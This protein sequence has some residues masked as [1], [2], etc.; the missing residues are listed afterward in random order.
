[1]DIP[2][3]S[4]GLTSVSDFIQDRIVFRGLV[5]VDP[6]LPPLAEY[7]KQAGQ[8]VQP[9]PRKHEPAYAG[10]V[11]WLLQHARRQAA[12]RSLIRRVL[13]IGDTRLSDGTAFDHI[14]QAGG[15][16][17]LIFIGAD[18]D[19]PAAISMEPTPGGQEL[20][21]AN[22]WTA[23][24][25]FEAY[26]AYKNFPIDEA[27][28]LLVD[29]DKT[30]IGARGR[31]DQVIDRARVQAVQDTVQGL[32]GEGF[33]KPVFLEAYQRLDR[34][35]YHPF[36][37]DNQ[38]YLAYI[39]LVL[40]SGYTSLGELLAEI[41][42]RERYTFSDFIG[43][44]EDRKAQLPLALRPIHT[45]IFD[46]VQSGDP[47]PFKAFRRNEYLSTSARMGCMPVDAP[48]VD[49]LKQE[50]VITE[51]VRQQAIRWQAQGALVFGLSD[52]P[53]EASVPTPEQASQ[54]ALPL[55]RIPTHSVGGI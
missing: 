42:M 52:K 15:W 6:S 31:N 41:Q 34:A 28:A 50:I 29:L 8:P 18:R 53:D 32:L 20:F 37:Q 49:L 13:F 23:L 36:T 19:A 16:N 12:P 40:G 48:V 10:Y 55:H 17:G 9:V 51:E 3:Q 54:G 30:A 44:V 25:D 1:M 21:L 7:W 5:P 35:D 43:R 22:R 2:M 14:C 45:E 27:T 24:L 4:S 38:D 11:A 26:L 33:N 46:L 47:T 39:C